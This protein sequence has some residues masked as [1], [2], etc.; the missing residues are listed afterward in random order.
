M[1]SDATVIV[2]LIFLDLASK[3]T[4]NF[5]VRMGPSLM[6]AL[7]VF[8]SFLLFR[9]RSR[10]IFR[11]LCRT[12]EVYEDERKFHFQVVNPKIEVRSSSLLKAV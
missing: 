8:M 12:A 5:G 6:L 10:S 4:Y 9:S 2:T 1:V 11:S 7:I 3:D